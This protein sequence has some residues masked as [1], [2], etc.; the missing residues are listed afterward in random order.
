MKENFINKFPSEKIDYWHT[1]KGLF[2]PEQLGVF[3]NMHSQSIEENYLVYF[4]EC[5]HYWQSIFTPYGHLKWGN[6][7]TVSSEVIDLWL[8]ATK[9][10]PTERVLP[11]GGVLP[12]QSKEQFSNVTQ[13]FIQDYSSKIVAL[14]ERLYYDEAI[15]D[16]LQVRGWCSVPGKLVYQCTV[17]KSPSS[18]GRADVVLLVLFHPEREIAEVV[19]HL[20]LESLRQR[21]QRQVHRCS[22]LQKSWRDSDPASI[23]AGQA[24][25]E[26]A[27]PV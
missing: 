3:L 11:I 27:L 19:I 6:H 14:E 24:A 20:L 4:H 23:L 1:I 5:F 8:K 16:M 9:D 17:R 10:T 18:L 15:K 12:C 22:F 26:S 2:T 13:I 7:R 21:L 25:D